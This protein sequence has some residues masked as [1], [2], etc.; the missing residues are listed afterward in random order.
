MPVG[1]CIGT[2][3]ARAVTS[4]GRGGRCAVMIPPPSGSDARADGASGRAA[5]IGFRLVRRGRSSP[6]TETP[7]GLVDVK[8]DANHPSVTAETSSPVTSPGLG[9]LLRQAEQIVRRAMAEPLAELELT[10]EQWRVVAAL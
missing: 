4:G 2:T 10:A 8:R 7:R 5:R 6:R 3:K 1:P 9:L